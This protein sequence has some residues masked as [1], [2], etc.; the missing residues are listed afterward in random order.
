MQATFH[1]FPTLH[2][3][4]LVL[5]QLV[6]ADAPEIFVHRSDPRMLEFVDIPVATTLEDAQQFIGKINAGIAENASIFWAIALKS[7]PKLIGTICL[8]NLSV[9][10]SA[11][12]LGYMLHPDFQGQGYMQ[13]ALVSTVAYA[14]DVMEVRL[15]EAFCQ[16]KNIPSVR[17]LE[18][19]GF[20]RS[21]E[22]DGYLHFAYGIAQYQAET[23]R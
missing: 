9:E 21:G 13:E 6:A 8:W 2:T 18:R 7:N 19:N 22:G 10:K 1:P 14:F 20:V 11:A 16:A 5:R 4:R 3:A 12:E 15:I 23:H 17:L